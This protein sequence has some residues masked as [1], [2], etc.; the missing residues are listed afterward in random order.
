MSDSDKEQ[1]NLPDAKELEK[2]FDSLVKKLKD[3]HKDLPP[4]EK[5]ALMELLKAAKTHT[6]Y[7]QA[8]DEG[9]VSKILYMKPIQVHSTRIMKQKMK[10]LPDE[11]KD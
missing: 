1:Q 11:F 9:D 6:D 7:V 2:A 4:E 10:N 5:E 8:R 3:F